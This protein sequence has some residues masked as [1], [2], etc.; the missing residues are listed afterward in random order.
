MDLI[1]SSRLGRYLLVGGTAFVVEYGSFIALYQGFNIQVY[2][3][4]SISFTFGLAVSF[5]FNR[6]W[7]FKSRMDYQLRVHHQ[8]LVYAILA[9]FNLLTTNFIIAALKTFSVDPKLGKLI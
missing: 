9:V 6:A 2:V 4:N 8:F 3:A 1:I 7:A 5:L